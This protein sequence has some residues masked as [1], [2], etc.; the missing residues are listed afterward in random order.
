MATL[1][2]Q[3]EFMYVISNVPRCVAKLGAISFALSWRERIQGLFAQC[4]L[5]QEACGYVRR[6]S[7]GV[8]S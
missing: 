3:D 6:S 1:S 7:H 4:A 8:L 2:P 5:V